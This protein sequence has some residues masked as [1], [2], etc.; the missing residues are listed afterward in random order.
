MPVLMLELFAALL[1][2]GERTSVILARM[3][4][5]AGTL[6]RV[7]TLGL[8][9]HPQ[10]NTVVLAS[11]QREPSGRPFLRSSHSGMRLVFVPDNAIHEKPRI[12]VREPK[13]RR[14]LASSPE[15]VARA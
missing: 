1:A 13:K 7:E 2:G 6:L 14:R 8:L 3:L 11:A 10:E 9:R 5:L 12:V 15:R 4:L